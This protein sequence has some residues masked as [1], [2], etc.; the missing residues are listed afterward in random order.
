MDFSDITSIICEF[1]P[2]HHGHK[3]LISKAKET[4]G[5]VVCVMSGNFVQRGEA[6]FADKYY[7]AKAAVTCGADLVL[8]IPFPYSMTSARDFASAGVHIVNSLDIKSLTFGAESDKKT[9]SPIA[10]VLCSGEADDYIAVNI[11]LSPNASY[12]KLRQKFIREKCGKE[13][14]DALDLPNNILALEYMSAIIK[15]GYR[16]EQEIIKRESSFMSSSEIRSRDDFCGLLPEESAAVFK[17]APLFDRENFSCFAIASLRNRTFEDNYYDSSSGLK[18]RILKYANVCDTL[19]ELTDKCVSASFTRSKCRRAIMAMLFGIPA[20]ISKKPSY[21][22][23]LCA[24]EKGREFL[25]YC[26]KHCSFPIITK[27]SSALDSAIAADFER[28][29]DAEN[30]LRVFYSKHVPHPLKRTP[31]IL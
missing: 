16:T 31:E 23:V 2:F 4:H 22:Q 9:L 30:T 21:T 28:E 5:T 19:G 25:A 18:D 1:N 7:R 6:A 12:A 15:N 13:A 29:A 20:D 14:S 11:A 10:S 3:Y 27:P 8:S 17:D 26:R 24:N